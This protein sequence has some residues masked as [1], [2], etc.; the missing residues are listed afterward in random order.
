MRGAGKR[1]EREHQERA[2]LAWHVAAL[3]RQKTLPDFKNF[4]GV[5]RRP[6]QTQTPEVLEAMGKAL[7]SAW[8][9]ENI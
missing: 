7:A 3:E 4:A 5:H 9:A 6:G 8:G 1:I 2:W